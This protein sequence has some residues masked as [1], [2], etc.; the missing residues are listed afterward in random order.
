[1]AEYSNDVTG[2]DRG[3]GAYAVRV[4]LY[5]AVLALFLPLILATVVLGLFATGWHEHGAWICFPVAVGF[6]FLMLWTLSRIAA[7]K[8]QNRQPRNGAGP[9]PPA[10]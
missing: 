1:M 9:K 5:L 7:T 3:S 4:V 8:G 10:A 6:F 2:R